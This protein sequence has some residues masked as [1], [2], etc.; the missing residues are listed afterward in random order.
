MFIF[1]IT[2]W[3]QFL[4]HQ[5]SSLSKLTAGPFPPDSSRH[6]QHSTQAYKPWLNTVGTV[7]IKLGRCMYPIRRRL[8][9]RASWFSCRAYRMGK[10]HATSIETARMVRHTALH[11]LQSKPIARSIPS[12]PTLIMEDAE[13]KLCS[14]STV[15]KRMPSRD[16][17]TCRTSTF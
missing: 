16:F 14:R 1:V 10:V 3:E 17:S 8:V 12:D 2:R 6:A 15:I 13:S 7:W 9:L 11:S 4:T 5:S